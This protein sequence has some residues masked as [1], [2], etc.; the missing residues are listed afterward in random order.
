MIIMVTTIGETKMTIVV[1]MTEEPRMKEIEGA[2]EDMIGGEVRKE[3]DMTIEG[4]N[5]VKNP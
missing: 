2:S 1:V 5:N 4:Y 3:D